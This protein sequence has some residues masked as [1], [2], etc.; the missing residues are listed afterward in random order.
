MCSRSFGEPVQDLPTLIEVVSQFTTQVARKLREQSSLAGSVHVFLAT[1]PYRRQDRQ[2]APS[3]TFPLARPASDTRVLISAAVLALR[4]IHR[5]GFNYVK[6]GVMLVDLVDAAQAAS[7]PTL[8]EAEPRQD[9]PGEP[10]TRLMCAMDTLNQRYGRET[11]TIASAARRPGP[12][13]HASRQSRRTPRYT[14][15]LDEIAT[16]RA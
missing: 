11:V 2:H 16:A 8:F 4:S 1:S 5:P 3:A 10:R 6:T 14:T 13:R 12:S 7:A 15:R 9:E